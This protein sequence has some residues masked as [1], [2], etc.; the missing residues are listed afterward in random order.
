MSGKDKKKLKVG[1][2]VGGGPP[3]GYKWNVLFLSLAQKESHSLLAA[4]E[5]EHLLQQF[6]DMATYGEPLRC[7]HVSIDQIEDY[8]ELKDQGGIFHNR[9]VRVFFGLDKS[10]K[11]NKSIVVLG[12]YIKKTNSQTP[13]G[14]RI[15]MGRRWRKYKA[16]EYKEV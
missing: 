7:P 5:H 9:S 13:N 12:V 10:D 6:K 11:D 2:K 16:G 14:T 1:L 15:T 3:P 4:G 8:H